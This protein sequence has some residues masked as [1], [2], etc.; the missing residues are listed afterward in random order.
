[1]T[2]LFG[3]AHNFV[4]RKQRQS[5][6]GFGATPGL[7]DCRCV[8]CGADGLSRSS[9]AADDIHRDAVI[10]GACG[11][12]YDSSWGVPFIGHFERDD[13][14]GLIEIAQ[15]SSAITII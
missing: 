10:C 8:R 1:M 13:F 7:S 5:Q 2:E 4:A 15:M 11:A 12:T 9:E 14:L 3:L 6:I